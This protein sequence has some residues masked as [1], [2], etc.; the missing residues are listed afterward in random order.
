MD[1][2][3]V[4][5]AVEVDVG[6]RVFCLE[7]VEPAHEVGD[8]FFRVSD[9]YKTSKMTKDKRGRGVRGDVGGAREGRG[10]V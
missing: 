6:E 7:V 10:G 8:C 5:V 9:R 4:E 2:Y 3:G 1:E